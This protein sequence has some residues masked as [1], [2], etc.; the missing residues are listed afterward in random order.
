ML[1][2]AVAVRTFNAVRT[3]IR[4]K[5]GSR[6]EEFLCM[7]ILLASS[8]MPWK[9]LILMDIGRSCESSEA[10]LRG[11]WFIFW[12]RSQTKPRC[13]GQRGTRIGTAAFA[14]IAPNAGFGAS[15]RVT[16]REP[17]PHVSH[18]HCQAL[19]LEMPP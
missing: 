7:A 2:S 19:A 11:I 4:A 13:D 1:L 9:V 12:D 17:P 18:S 15:S 10:N 3:K 6:A 5:I 8:N 14:G 16:T